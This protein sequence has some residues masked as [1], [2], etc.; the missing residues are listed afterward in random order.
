MWA[1]KPGIYMHTRM[2]SKIQRVLKRTQS[3]QQGSSKGLDS[4]SSTP[5]S[6]SYWQILCT[7]Q[8]GHRRSAWSLPHLGL[9]IN[10]NLWDRKK[11]KPV[12]IENYKK[13]NHF[14][15]SVLEHQTRLMCVR[16]LDCRRFCLALQASTDANL[17][18]HM[19]DWTEYA[20][21]FSKHNWCLGCM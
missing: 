12:W 20:L 6:H 13:A 3:K 18:K 1:Y 19:D 17:D 14:S 5:R 10:P 4:L 7:T 2:W 9:R 16:Q 11:I 21:I 8:A 15:S